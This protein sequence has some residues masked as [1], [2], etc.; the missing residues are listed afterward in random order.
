MDFITLLSANA[1]SDGIGKLIINNLYAWISTWSTNWGMLSAFSITVI[2]FSIFLKLAVLPIDIWQKN[3]ARKNTKIMDGMKPALEKITKQCGGNKELLMQKQRALYKEHKYST[4]GACLPMVLT[5]AVFFVIFGGFNSAVRMYNEK[6]YKDLSVVYE[7]ARAEE[8]GNYNEIQ[9]TEDGKTK[10][11]YEKDGITY[12]QTEIVKLAIDKAEA[13]VLANY[14]PEGFLFTIN[15]FVADS[16]KDPIPSVDDFAGSGMGKSNIADANDGKYEIVMRPIMEKYNTR[17]NGY[18]LLPLF[19]FA[20]NLV[21]MKLNKPPE[22]PTV[23][24]Q[25]EEQKKAQQSQAKLMQYLM[26]AMML[27]FALF[28][29]SAF[30]LYMLINSVFTTIFNLSYNIVTKKIDAKEKDRFLS[31]SLKK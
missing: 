7:T 18:L 16:W 23:A 6:T 15:I 8:L 9:I 22:Q 19:V 13:A 21:S 25:T 31:T 26:P 5:L 27:V 4:F 14:K 1:I 17:W 12:P 2:M 30:T 24:G 3:L 10:T 29:S 28:Y 11:A 20:L